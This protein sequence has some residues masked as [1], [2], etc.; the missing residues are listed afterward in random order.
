MYDESKITLPPNADYD[1][2]LKAPHLRRM[3]EYAKKNEWTFFEPR[4]FE[5]GRLR[6]HHGYL[7]LVTQT[8]F[9]V[10]QMLDWLR[11]KGLEGDTIVVY[12][13]DHGDYAC[14]H[15]IME[16]AP[17]ICADAITRIPFIWRWPGRFKAG[18]AAKEIVETVDMVDTLC[19]LC[20]LPRLETSDGKDLSPL[21]SGEAREVHEIGVTEFA[22][23][24]SVRKGDFR[25]VYYPRDMF[26]AEY[27]KG[28]GEL[29]NVKQDPW[30][31]KN[32]FF[33][34][35]HAERIGRMKAELLD[36]L[37]TTT[38]TKTQLPGVR[39]TS[40]QAV[41]RYKNATNPDGKFDTDRIRALVRRGGL[42]DL[43]YL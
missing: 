29:Y 3:A 28:F 27:P 12:T 10:G 38:R 25:L 13:T 26:A 15:G 31:M 6:K 5:A 17:G 16:K 32:L 39:Y 41:M 9:A 2:S 19:A 21:L 40:P 36:W 30:E 22:W 33:D 34:P 37:V 14:E 8:D 42:H 20:G 23:S 35:T 1:M 24:R 11:E 7:G 18:H 4:T 43:N